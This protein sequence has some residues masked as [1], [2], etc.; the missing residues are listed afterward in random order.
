MKN[1]ALW[2]S[3]PRVKSSP[4]ICNTSLH[5]WIFFVTG[6][7]FQVTALFPGHNFA[8]KWQ[9]CFQ[10]TSLFPGHSFVSSSQLCFQFTTLF[11]GHNFVSRSQ[12]CF[13]VTTFFPG[14]R[15]HNVRGFHIV[16]SEE[17]CSKTDMK[18]T[19]MSVCVLFW[20][21]LTLVSCIIL[22]VWNVICVKVATKSLFQI[23]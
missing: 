9:L 19:E 6:S 17:G 20:L 15:F 13:Q 10:V 5:C 8:S 21:V 23:H 3:K 2:K 4:H 7:Y 12:L 16:T 18:A 22:M 1:S 11:P 14:H